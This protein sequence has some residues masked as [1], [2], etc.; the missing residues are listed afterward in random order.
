MT[1]STQITLQN[2]HLEGIIWVFECLVQWIFTEVK[3]WIVGA[4][5]QEIIVY[6]KNE[7]FVPFVDKNDQKSKNEALPPPLLVSC[8]CKVKERITRNR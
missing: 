3:V 2:A 8:T 6:P 1:L 5:I 7:R 4:K